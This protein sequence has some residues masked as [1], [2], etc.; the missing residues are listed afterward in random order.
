MSSSTMPFTIDARS[1]APAP[2][3]SPQPA[4]D[5]L[6][7]RFERHLD[8]LQSPQQRAPAPPSRPQ[9]PQRA[10]GDDAAR[11]PLAKEGRVPADRPSRDEP[12]PEARGDAA[13]ERNA[14][15]ASSRGLLHRGPVQERDGRDAAQAEAA[16]RMPVSRPKS[17]GDRVVS[18]RPG[19]D[20]RARPE[21]DAAASLAASWSEHR[22]QPMPDMLAPQAGAA[23]AG[24]EVL[25]PHDVAAS[26]SAAWVE[27]APQLPGAAAAGEQWT[28][29][30]GDPMTPLA[31]LRI[32]GDAT[33]GWALRLSAGAGLPAQQLAAQ[34]A[35]LRERLSARG[36]AVQRLDVDDEEDAS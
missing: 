30:I 11:A 8:G 9:P 15:P 25:T 16:E 26:V 6:R 32:T 34:G 19:E 22:F 10:P 1:L 36:H 35:R 28:F 29:S 27:Q 2:A 18:A 12:S 5:E 31:A 13:Q 7:Q 33:R 20:E 21:D 17:H 3:P 24:P 4:G 23:A 14:H